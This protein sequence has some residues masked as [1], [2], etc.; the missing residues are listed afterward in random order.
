IAGVAVIVR[1]GVGASNIGHLVMLVAAFGFGTAIVMMKSLTRTDAV[2]VI[3]F[4]MLVIQSAIGVAPA[5]YY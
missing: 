4:W 5:L 1:P 2:V 3:I